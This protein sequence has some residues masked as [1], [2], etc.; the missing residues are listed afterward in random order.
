MFLSPEQ[1]LTRHFVYC[2]L[3]NFFSFFRTLGECSPTRCVC[4]C[5][6]LVTI[7][8]CYNIHTLIE[9]ACT[10]I[11]FRLV[12]KIQIIIHKRIVYTNKDGQLNVK[13][14]ECQETVIIIIIKLWMLTVLTA[15]NYTSFSYTSFRHLRPQIAKATRG[16]RR[17]RVTA[18]ITDNIVK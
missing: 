10:W 18:V 9:L 17:G 13:E 1:N 8:V 4:C 7:I 12:I 16:G 6:V 11:F 3:F 14:N 5:F 15:T 2:F